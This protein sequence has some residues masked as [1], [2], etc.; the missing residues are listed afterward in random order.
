MASTSANDLNEVFTTETAGLQHVLYRRQDVLLAV[1]EADQ[2]RP[3][4]AGRVCTGVGRLCTRPR[5]GNSPATGPTRGK[6][7][8]RWRSPED[9]GGL[10]TST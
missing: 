6:L 10:E 7:H 5:R 1:A 9:G 3:A 4:G 2:P 8:A